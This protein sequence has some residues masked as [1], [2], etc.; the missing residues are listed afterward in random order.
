MKKGAILILTFL[1]NLSIAS[2]QQDIRLFGNDYPIILIAPI[3]F[4]G[5]I[6]LFFFGLIIKDNI[7]KLKLPKINL[8]KIK[9][10]H[11]EKK[12]ISREARI[13][14]KNKFSILKEKS[15]RIG[16]QNS[17]NELGEI[18]KNFL[19]EKFNIK[20]E[21]AF[22]ELGNLIKGHAKDISLANKISNLKYSG[23]SIDSFQVKALFR[24]FENLLN[25]YKYKEEQPELGFFGRVKGNFLK[26]FKRKEV[27][28][29]IKE[30]KVK[31]PLKQIPQP[32]NIIEKKPRIFFSLFDN[33]RS[34]FKKKEIK[35]KKIEVKPKKI[36]KEEIKEIEPVKPAKKYKFVLFNNLISKI[37]KFRVLSLIKRGRK[38]LLTNPLLAKRYYAR[39]LLSYY[40]MPINEE[41]E[42]MDNLMD[43]HNN[44]LSNRSH[45]KTFLDISKNL[46]EMKH[47]GKHVSRESISM[48]NTLKNFI[49]REE[50]LAA[51]RLKEFSYK[52]KHEE[53]KLGHF[54]KDN[55]IKDFIQGE[56]NVIK[57][58]I[59]DDLKK[60]GTA[61]SDKKL[62]KPEIAQK[63]INL[64]DH[65]N[66][67][68]DF[69][70]KQPK[71]KVEHEI[72]HEEKPK[73]IN[74]NLRLLQKQRSDLYNKLMKLEEGKI[75]HNKLN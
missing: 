35:I 40:K 32:L 64:V 12:E 10:K 47:K 60:F 49:E 41:K 69:L 63:T 56:E 33:L 26:I 17:F 70:Y 48:L 39:A 57:N 15:S 27:K 30:L 67:K 21:F 29:S 31:A 54:L 11:A 44:I 25:E 65:Y 16:I 38:T 45:E 19:K 7:G 24:E 8:S 5:V 51:T 62:P 34:I 42:I 1:L 13:D 66:P 61:V 74:K 58:N 68:L 55:K 71:I 9:V 14:S 18:I 3:F 43:F 23:A 53:K 2:A 22:A 50:L 4:M 6:A 28:L 20:H 46:I 52:L 75:T 59:K 36:I 37:Q 72:E 73:I